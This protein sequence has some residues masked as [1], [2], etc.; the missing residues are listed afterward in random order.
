MSGGHFDYQQYRMEDIAD[1]IDRLIDEN[2]STKKY[3][4]GEDIGYHFPPEIIERF[5]QTAHTLRQAHEMTQRVDRLISGDDGEE[6][7]M[8]RW[9]NEV[10]K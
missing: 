5:K 6:S 10:R 4:G 2:D 9:D 3:T 8:S 7:F 1:G